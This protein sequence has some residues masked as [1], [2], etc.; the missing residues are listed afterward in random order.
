MKPEFEYVDLV[1]ENCNSVRIPP[2]KIY[3][4]ALDDITERVFINTSHQYIEFKKCKSFMI[5]LANDALDIKTSFQ[6]DHESSESSSFVNHIKKYKD[7][8]RVVIKINK[9]EELDVCIPYDTKGTED[10]DKNLLQKNKF[11][12]DT[13]TISAE[14]K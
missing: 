7:I 1:F 3:Y 5:T 10:S 12:K 2:D 9:K 14:E 4:L 6:K 13:F 11:N 8:T